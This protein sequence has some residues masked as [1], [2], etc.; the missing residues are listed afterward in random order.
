M[1]FTIMNEGIIFSF[2]FAS[3]R[4]LYAPHPQLP[5]TSDGFGPTRLRVPPCSVQNQSLHSC[6]VIVVEIIFMNKSTYLIASLFLLILGIFFLIQR[7]VSLKS[8]LI[9]EPSPVVSEKPVIDTSSCERLSEDQANEC[10]ERF[11]LNEKDEELCEK[12][13]KYSRRKECEREVELGVR[14]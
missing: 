4:S 13:T 8:Q 6:S 9:T 3:T 14:N 11:A 1:N 7:S 5:E 2:A 10:Y 12:I